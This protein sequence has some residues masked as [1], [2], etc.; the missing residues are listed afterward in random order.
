MVCANIGL[1]SLFAAGFILMGA[2]AEQMEL[3]DA[4]SMD[5]VSYIL[6]LLSVACIVF[7][8]T[9]MLVHLYD[10][11]A[12]GHAGKEGNH[13]QGYMDENS[14]ESGLI[15]AAEDFELHGLV[16]DDEGET[17]RMLHT[18]GRGQSFESSSAS[19]AGKNSHARA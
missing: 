11:L 7:L 13:A 14:I 5:H 1:Q 18:E 17:T 4:S 12:N 19:T 8:F 10:R 2:T 16:S 6:V 15:R 3:I 9:N